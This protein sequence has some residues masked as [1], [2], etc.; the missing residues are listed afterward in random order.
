MGKLYSGPTRGIWTP[1][2]TFATPGDLNIAYTSQFGEWFLRDGLLTQHFYIV[3]S[4]FTHTTASGNLRIT[5]LHLPSKT[6]ATMQWA[7][8]LSHLR[9]VT[10]ASFTHF[11]VS[12]GSAATFLSILASGSAV[13]EAVLT[14]ADLPTGT[15]K[16]FCGQI[17]YPVA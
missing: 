2:L 7:G 14:V 16:V 13:T 15:T 11:G 8:A 10:K 3:T 6:L 9:G 17:T 5:G 4:T 12:V 1:A